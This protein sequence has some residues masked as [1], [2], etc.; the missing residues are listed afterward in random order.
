MLCFLYVYLFEISIRQALYVQRNIEVLSLNRLCRRKAVRITY[1]QCLIY[2]VCRT[3]APYYIV[4]SELS[5]C[6]VF[7]H[8]FF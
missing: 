5:L 8:I 2:L 6:T 3:Q 4:I 1:S 7:F